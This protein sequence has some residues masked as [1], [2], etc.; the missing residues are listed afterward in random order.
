MLQEKRWP[1][2]TEELVGAVITSLD[3]EYHLEKDGID[4][5]LEIV[6]DWP[7]TCFCDCCCTCRPSSYFRAFRV[8]MVEVPEPKVK[9]KGK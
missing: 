8:E 1:V 9:K 2:G 5:R 7:W 6:E 4:Y 3:W